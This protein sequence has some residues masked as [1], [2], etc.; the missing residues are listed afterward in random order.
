MPPP[1]RKALVISADPITLATLHAA[2]HESGHFGTVLQAA[3]ARAIYEHNDGLHLAI[4]DG[5]EEL[6]PDGSVR[7]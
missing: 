6:I 4:I 3:S 5:G 7:R 1:S 2:V